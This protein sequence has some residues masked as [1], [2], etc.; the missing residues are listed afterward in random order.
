LANGENGGGDH[1]IKRIDI[2]TQK[3]GGQRQG[4]PIGNTFSA[5]STGMNGVWQQEMSSIMMMEPGGG[6]GSLNGTMTPTGSVRIPPNSFYF[7]LHIS[8]KRL[9][10]GAVEWAVLPVAHPRQLLSN[11]SNSRIECKMDSIMGRMALLAN[12]L[13]IMGL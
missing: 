1:P 2:Q 6:I 11:N 12:P 10:L 3:L 13:L 7:N 4:M 8:N 9:R 5:Q